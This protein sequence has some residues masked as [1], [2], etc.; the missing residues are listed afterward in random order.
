MGAGELSD[1]RCG[2]HILLVEDSVD[3]AEFVRQVLEEEGYRL[4]WAE[5]ADA[6]LAALRESRSGR[7]N[8]EVTRGPDLVLLDLTLPD[9]NVATF[10]DEIRGLAGPQLPLVIVSALPPAAIDAAA[11]AVNAAAVIRKPF[12]IDSLLGTVADVL[13]LGV[14][15]G[16]PAEMSQ[17]QLRP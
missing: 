1:V 14:G 17:S 16:L 13:A 6:A 9:M 12:L 3:S 5:T 10:V 11:G 2:A 15:Q 7:R 8:G 4:T